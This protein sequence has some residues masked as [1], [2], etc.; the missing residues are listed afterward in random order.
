MDRRLEPPEPHLVAYAGAFPDSR[1]VR[2]D[3]RVLARHGADPGVLK[4]SND[5]PDA[6]GRQAEYFRTI[7]S[8]S[9]SE[10]SEATR[11]SSAG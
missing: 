9:S 5:V 3:E 11:I 8:V 2:A 1:A 10:A 4:V 7:S 6:V